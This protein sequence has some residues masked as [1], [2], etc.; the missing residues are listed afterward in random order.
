M[1]FSVVCIL[2]DN[3]TGHHILKDVIIGM[4]FLYLYLLLT[5]FEV[6]TVS[7]GPSFFPLI[8]GPSAKRAGY[9]S[10]GKNEDP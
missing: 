6:R 4:I 3:D 2:I 1:W 8:Y 10:T 5:E 9:E 7:Y